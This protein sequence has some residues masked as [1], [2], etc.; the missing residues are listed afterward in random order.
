MQLN[1]MGKVHMT[2]C[3]VAA[4]LAGLAARHL[5]RHASFGCTSRQRQR[6]PTALVLRHREKLSKHRRFRHHGRDR[7][8][9]PG[10]ETTNNAA[11]TATLIPLLTLGI[12]T[13]NTTAI[14]LGAFQNYSINPGLAAVRQERRA[15]VSADRVAVHRQRDAAGAQPA[16]GGPVGEAA[17]DPKPQLYAGILIFATVGVYGMRQSAFDLFLLYAI[18]LLGVLMRALT[19]RPRRWW[20]A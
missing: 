19:S 4:F 2:R 8:R 18:G 16:A 9:G 1:R 17:E 20:W 14:L 10:P 5:H 6:I 7:R 12:P 13:S 15:G 3:G 11:I